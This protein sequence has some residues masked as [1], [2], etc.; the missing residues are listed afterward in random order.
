MVKKVSRAVVVV[1]VAGVFGGSGVASAN[2]GGEVTGPTTEVTVP[3]ATA[4]AETGPPTSAPTSAATAGTD[5]HTTGHKVGA[6]SGLPF[7]SGVFAHSPERVA[8]YE[9]KTGRKVDLWQ[10][11]PQR[12]EGDDVMLSETQRTAAEIPDGATADWAFPLVS[13]EQ[14]ARLG[15]VINAE[16]PTAYVRFGWEFNGDWWPWSA[17]KVGHDKWVADYKAAVDGLRSTAPNVRVVWNPNSGQGGIPEAM[18]SWP[19]D[20]YVD[21]IGVDVYDWANEDPVKGEGQLDE[22]AAEARKRGKKIALPE[23]GVHGVEG[24][25]DNPA[26]VSY[27]HLR[28]HET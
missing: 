24:R 22:W 25:G 12:K 14:A 19:G 26:S 10:I 13:R 3:A 7:D 2:D 9:Q 17:E 18:K 23:W 6:R 21:V 28:A 8:R 16:T 27:T 1:V 4:P 5:A 20:D 15:E 11:A